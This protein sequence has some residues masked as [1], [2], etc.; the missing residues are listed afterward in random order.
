MPVG[1][2][3]AGIAAVIWSH[4]SQQY[5]L[6]R[7]SESKDF[8]GGIWE[9]PTGR[10]NQGEGFEDALHREVTEELGQDLQVEHI[11]GTTHFYRG[12]PTPDNELLGVVYLC[13][14][15]SPVSIHLS[16]EHSE[17]R[18]LPAEQA[19]ELLSATDA[20]TRWAHRVIE[21]AELIR[22]LLPSRLVDFQLRAGFEIG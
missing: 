19:L 16:S 9:C 7:R 8:A 21:R 6:L 5:L 12:A 2:F 20:S 17:Y 3:I 4:E 11:L 13:A 14:M 18:W 22:P 15:P 1:H 10:V